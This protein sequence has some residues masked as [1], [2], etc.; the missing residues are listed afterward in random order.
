MSA[1]E[2]MPLLSA[3]EKRG[4]SLSRGRPTV[5]LF[6]SLPS[7]EIL[8]CLDLHAAL[9]LLNTSRVLRCD[10]VLTTSVLE[11]VPCSQHFFEGCAADWWQLT[12]LWKTS[13][14]NSELVVDDIDFDWDDDQLLVGQIEDCHLQ[15]RHDVSSSR[16]SE[17]VRAMPQWQHMGLLSIIAFLQQK[18]LPQCYIPFKYA[19]AVYTARP[20]ILPVSLTMEQQAHA[21]RGS[22][23]TP[24]WPRDELETAL[25]MLQK[26]FGSAFV[27]D[28]AAPLTSLFGV[29]WDNMEITSTAVGDDPCVCCKTCR[30]YASEV[31]QYQD[32]VADMI[33]RWKVAVNAQLPSWKAKGMHQMEIDKRTY[34]MREEMIPYTGFYNSNIARRHGDIIIQHV[35]SHWDSLEHLDIATVGCKEASQLL[36]AMTADIRKQCHHFARLK[37]AMLSAFPV[38]P[39]SSS[40]GVRRMQYKLG[41]PWAYV[42]MWQEEITTELVAGFS[43]AGFVC[44]FLLIEKGE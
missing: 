15:D 36:L 18:I 16:W 26:G 12:P 41:D 39:C 42:N 22:L 10:R 3:Y 21:Q 19:S 29:H 43:S 4:A 40:G 9:Q 28:D 27:R 33:A 30:L 23:S 8:A 13:I 25:N 31:K 5:S 1:A 17:R 34:V 35:C 7:I 2:L 38:S 11:R 44:G 24:N 32:I 6:F 37:H 14:H 20:F